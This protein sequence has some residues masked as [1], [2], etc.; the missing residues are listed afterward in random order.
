MSSQTP[1]SPWFNH[2]NYNSQCFSSGSSFITL[3]YA[4]ANYLRITNG[5]T[6]ISNSTSTTFN[7]VIVPSA[8][9]LPM[10]VNSRPSIGYTYTGTSTFTFN[11]SVLSS[12]FISISS[13]MSIPFG[14]YLIQATGRLTKQGASFNSSTASFTS[15]IILQYDTT[16]ANTSII[17]GIN[18]YQQDFINNNLSSV[19]ECA[20]VMPLTPMNVSAITA[21]PGFNFAWQNFVGTG[22]PGSSAILNIYWNITRFA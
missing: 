13:G 1:P 19:A 17:G 2:I 7:G 3:P 21:V 6:P 15:G 8:S 11:S 5:S 9:T 22:F 18:L 20:V 16:I 4:N 10:I 14:S 12:S